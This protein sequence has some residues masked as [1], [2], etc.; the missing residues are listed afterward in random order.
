MHGVACLEEWNIFW[1]P[2][3]GHGLELLG[4]KSASLK[5]PAATGRWIT[6]ANT[7]QMTKPTASRSAVQGTGIL[8]CGT[9]KTGMICIPHSREKGFYHCCSERDKEFHLMPGY[10]KDT[11]LYNDACCF[12]ARSVPSFPKRYFQSSSG[13]ILTA[14]ALYPQKDEGEDN[15]EN[16]T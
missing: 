15:A 11:G 5:P 14:S 16:S 2:V 7:K 8:L 4:D 9:A 12:S 3:R 1:S 13:W 6:W 10:S